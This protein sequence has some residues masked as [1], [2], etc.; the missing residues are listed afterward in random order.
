M[1]GL[2]PLGDYPPVL[3][4]DTDTATPRQQI[5][6]Y[7]LHSFEEPFCTNET[8]QCFVKR[9]EIKSLFVKIVEGKFNLEKAVDLIDDTQREE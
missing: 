5:P 7:Y 4:F 9:Q 8:C 2:D 6:V 1:Q 3:S